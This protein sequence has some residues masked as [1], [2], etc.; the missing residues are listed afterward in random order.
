L[1]SRDEEV[2]EAVKH[3]DTCGSYEALDP[4]AITPRDGNRIFSMV[5]VVRKHLHTVISKGKEGD[6]ICDTADETSTEPD[7][8]LE[9]GIF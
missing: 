3:E 5:D 4:D 9:V 2:N 6:E 7:H 1:G 8:L